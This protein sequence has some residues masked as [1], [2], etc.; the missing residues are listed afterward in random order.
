MQSLHSNICTAHYYS[1]LFLALEYMH[2]N[3]IGFH[4]LRPC[5]SCPISVPIVYLISSQLQSMHCL[6]FIYICH[7]EIE[8]YWFAFLLPCDRFM[9]F[10]SSPSYKCLR[11]LP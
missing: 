3:P 1:D 7:D 6:Y 5:D 2:S 9:H 8:S 4:F 11:C 10:V